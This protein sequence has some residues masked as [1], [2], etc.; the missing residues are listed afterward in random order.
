MSPL[1]VIIDDDLDL[2]HLAKRYLERAEL[3]WRTFP[4]G[5]PALEWLADTEHP[6]AVIIVDLGLPDISGFDVC[7]RLRT[8]PNTRDIPLIAMSAR[9]GLD[10]EARVEET[11]AVLFLRKPLRGRTLVETVEPHVRAAM[12]R[13]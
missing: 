2:L 11:G 1:V 4:L 3:Q 6:L 9:D 13:A 10:D 7:E 8:H 5:Q 12:E